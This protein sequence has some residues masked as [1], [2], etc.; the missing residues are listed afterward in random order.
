MKKIII[1]L[2]CL[3][4][5]PAIYSQG[6]NYYVD[7][8]H[9][10]TADK[11]NG[12]KQKPFKSISEAAALAGPGDTVYVAGTIYRE[13]VAPAKGGTKENPVVYMATRPGVTIRGSEVITSA[14]S[15]MKVA[16]N[17]YSTV[18]D[19]SL[20][21]DF[22]PFLVKARALKGER[23]LGQ[24]FV[25]GKLFAEVDNKESLKNTPGTWYIA[26]DGLTLSV[27]FDKYSKGPEGKFIEVS[28]RNRI[29][30]PHQRGLGYVVVKGFIMEHC[31]NQF[32]ASFWVSDREK[33]YPQ[34]GALSTRSGNHWIIEDNIIRF[35]NTLGIDCGKEGGYDIEGNQPEPE[36]TGYHIIKNNII[37]DNGTCGIAGAGSPG[38]K[39][40]YN[41]ID[42]NNSLGWTSPE[43]GGIKVHWFTDGLVEGNI[44]RNNDAHGIWLDNGCTNSRVTRNVV[45]GSR[46]SGIFLEMADG[47][48]LVDNNIVAY[49]HAGDGIYAHD[50]SGITAAHNLLYA[51]EH[52]G[53]LMRTV[54]DRKTTN[55]LGERVLVGTHDETVVNN[56]FMDNYRGQLSFPLWGGKRTYNNKSDYNLYI[57]GST[58]KWEGLVRNPFVVNAD[59]KEGTTI[60]DVTD[61]FMKHFGELNFEGDKTTFRKIFEMQPVL[62]FEWWKIFTGNDKNSFAPPMAAATLENGAVAQGSMSFSTGELYFETKDDAPFRQLFVP[63][64]EGVDYDYYGNK[65]E[66]DSILPG[67]F[68]FYNEGH[69]RFVLRAP[70][71]ER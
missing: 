13:R 26:K 3:Y 27:H 2:V 29:F 49:T 52:F 12:T 34:A 30:A 56:I 37:S 39:I 17:I 65:I 8:L 53:I 60:K 48:V 1:G 24:V 66:G 54:T 10:V 7:N 63:L 58:W 35:A 21:M 19:E 45:I 28:T 46:G 4:L 61:A 36:L 22:N 64:V 16:E 67:P 70:Y 9:P 57:T 40:L 41:Q 33:G 68:Q 69:T 47:P 31:S 5:V 32:P 50:A 6:K 42:R 20:F 23:T 62:T 51:N 43:V 25:N 14:W 38:T 15:R 55:P 18:L 11:S 59:T 71:V 44:L